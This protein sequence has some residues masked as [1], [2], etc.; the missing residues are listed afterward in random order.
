[1]SFEVSWECLTGNE[2]AQAPAEKKEQN[3]SPGKNAAKT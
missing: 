3:L 1:M 2:E